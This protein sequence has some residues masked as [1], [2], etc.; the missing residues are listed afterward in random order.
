[1]ELLE[2]KYLWLVT[3]AMFH[4]ID[5]PNHLEEITFLFITGLT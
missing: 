3:T 2:Y 4:P 5:F 1:M